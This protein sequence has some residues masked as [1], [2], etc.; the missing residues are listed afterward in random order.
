MGVSSLHINFTTAEEYRE[1]GEA[2]GYLQ[3]TGIQVWRGA[4][5]WPVEA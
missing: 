2:H 4:R 1:L 3:R 5:R